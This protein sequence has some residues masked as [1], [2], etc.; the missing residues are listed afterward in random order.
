MDPIS[1]TRLALV[2][3]ELSRRIHQLADLVSFPFRITQGL[4]T[5]S[6]QD[7]LFDQGRTAPGRIVTE[8]KGGYS[9]HNFGYAV[10]VVPFINGVPDWNDRDA[11]W[12]EIL[13]KAP[14]CGLSEGATWRTFPDFPHL[15]PSECPA[16]PT[17]EIRSLMA[18]GGLQAVWAAILPVES[19]AGDVTT[20]SAEG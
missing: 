11:Q 12:A 17:D 15:Y 5:Y 13:A 4:R 7:A 10:D 6:E 19:N 14:S 16:D 3:P 1:E 9:A 8:A 18:S 2:N 20:A